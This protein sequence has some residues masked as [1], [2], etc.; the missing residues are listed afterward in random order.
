MQILS[1]LITSVGI[2]GTLMA[3]LFTF[4]QVKQPINISK[5]E[6][7][8]IIAWLFLFILGCVNIYYTNC[9]KNEIVD[10]EQDNNDVNDKINNQ[11]GNEE[12]NNNLSEEELLIA[13]NSVLIQELKNANDSTIIIKN[14]NVTLNFYELAGYVYSDIKKMYNYEMLAG[15]KVI[16]SKVIILDYLSDDIIYIFDPQ[17]KNYIKYMPNNK[18]TFYCIIFHEDYSIYV[19]QP[20]RVIGGD[21]Y[22]GMDIL[23]SKADDEFTSLFK[24]RVHV[25]DLQLDEDYLICSSDYRIRIS[26]KDRYSNEASVSYIRNMSDIGI[27]L[28]NDCSYFSLNTDY[29]MELML[30]NQSDLNKVLSSEV[31]DRIITDSN[32]EEIYFEINNE[33]ETNE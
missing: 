2:L 3:L 17:E 5:R 7:I 23:L 22:G 28:Y 10:E 31:F 13:E 8:F 15:K 11:D 9:L 25:K 4:F 24:L 30:Y 32:V 20:I 21:Y 1:I 27:I 26:C 16:P 29:V 6:T 18:E 14:D 19:T 33:V 12:E